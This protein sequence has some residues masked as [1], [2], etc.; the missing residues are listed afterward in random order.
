WNASK[1]RTYRLLQNPDISFATDMVADCL[2]PAVIRWSLVLDFH[3][4][5]AC[6]AHPA[7]RIE[8]TT[9]DKTAVSLYW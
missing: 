7:E 6:S 5:S 3:G 1:D 4:N 2:I 9:A 8:E